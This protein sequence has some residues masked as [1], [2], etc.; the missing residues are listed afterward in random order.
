MP[1]IV[2]QTPF[3][4]RDGQFAPD[5]EWIAHQSDEGG[6]PDIFVQPF[7]RAG[8]KVGVSGWGGTQPRWRRDGKELF[9]LSAENQ[10]MAVP[11]TRDTGDQM[12]FGVPVALFSTNAVPVGG[13]RRQQY[14]VTDDGSRFLINVVADDASAAPITIV[15]NWDPGR[16]AR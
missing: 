6:R 5:G 10:M 15:L 9:Y 4:E 8:Q 13:A 11:V 12:K 3:D 16:S 2:A 7:Q 1:I 14:V